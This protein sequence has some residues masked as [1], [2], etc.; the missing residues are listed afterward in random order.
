VVSGSPAVSLAVVAAVVLATILFALLGV[1]RIKMNP[2]QFIVGGRSFG[3]LFLWVLLAG[4]IY[5]SFTFLGAAGWAYG[6]GA[7]AY[8]ILSYGTCAYIL[9]YF[10]LPAVWRAG[11]EH[12]LLTGPDFFT[13]FY[14]SKTLTVAIAVCQFVLVVPYVTL[15]L[16]ALQILLQI[17]GYGR[18]DAT[19]SV[20][21]AFILIAL[22][23]LTAG[24][25]GTA[26]A[27]IIKDLLV[28][29]AVL[30]AGVTIPMRFFGSPAAML[31]RMVQVHPR[32][33]ALVPGTSAHGTIWFVTTV[34]L[35]ATG[36]FM[37]PQ[38]MIATYSGK[39]EAALRRNA[40]LL[41][42]YQ[43]ILLLMIFAGFSALLIAPGLHGTQVDRSFLTV[44]AR[45]YPSWVLGL[46]AA[47]GALAALVPASGLLL[48]AAS[49]FVKNVLGDGFGVTA[50]DAART[51]ATRIA[52]I[53][54]ALLALGLWLAVPRTIVELLLIYYNGITQFAPGVFAALVWRRANAWS[55][56]AGLLAGFAVAIP[57]TYANVEPWGI[58]AGFAA[59][60]INAAV[61]VVVSLLKPSGS[62]DA[63]RSSPGNRPAYRR[64]D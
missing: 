12:D 19:A 34:L 15:Q 37:G 45:Y 23:V 51:P 42:L 57:L 54:V 30:F 4:E 7:P 40:M 63:T 32:M 60:L 17:A 16:S 13:A 1:H 64:A 18:Y 2:R 28:I 21:L 55:V 52:V 61:V 46:I 33:L 3:T 27:S 53:V 43:L 48:A 56:G 39:S 58:N 31:D 50:S 9:G 41:P 24:L 22:F 8:Y 36:F 6:L 25:R 11:K 10:L 49:V 14:G 20:A 47:A 35:T 59:L 44:V 29:G 38:S 5:T 26:W 62:S